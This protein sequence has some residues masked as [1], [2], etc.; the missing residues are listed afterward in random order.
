M[1][2]LTFD[3][4]GGGSAGFLPTGGGDDFSLPLAGS[5]Q[6]SGN[7]G[8]L[9][10]QGAGS[11]IGP[12]TPT[13]PPVEPDEYAPNGFGGPQDNIRFLPNGLST[14]VQSTLDD[15]FSRSY[16][17]SNGSPATF[18]PTAGL[19]AQ[20]FQLADLDFTMPNI[21]L[22]G[23]ASRDRINGTAYTFI[24]PTN[25]GGI[26]TQMGV[27]EDV[28]FDVVAAQ[29]W[30]HSMVRA[31]PQLRG[32]MTAQ[33]S[34]ILGEAAS[35]AVSPDYAY[36]N[37]RNAVL[38]ATG[39]PSYRGITRETVAA[40]D[41]LGTQFG[42]G[43]GRDFLRDYVTWLGASG[44]VTGDAMTEASVADFASQELGLDPAT[45]IPAFETAI[46]NHFAEAAGDILD[47][48]LPTPDR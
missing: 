5:S 2:L 28:A 16:T 47:A 43:S 18:T 42:F 34:E 27:S 36:V 13:L 37:L 11:L 41:D 31:H 9:L 6:P 8:V 35:L 23:L 29:E 25:L 4:I 33:E 30:T 14:G 22:A 7:A 45:F 39:E 10:A 3:Q 44:P 40:L 48:R 32:K 20:A 1:S 21:D 26:A 12:V 46:T 19:S 15:L 38:G 17:D 24:S